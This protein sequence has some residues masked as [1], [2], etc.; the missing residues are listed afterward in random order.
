MSRTLKI[1]A[2]LVVVQALAVG[3]WFAVQRARSAKVT[4]TI[5]VLSRT[6]RMDR[7]APGLALKRLGGS[8]A[9]LSDFAGRPVVLHFWATWCGPC[10]DELPGLLALDKD[11]AAQ[12]LAVGLDS[13]WDSVRRFLGRD[14]PSSVFL[15]DSKMVEGAFNVRRL[16]VTYILD[17]RGRLRLRMDGP[18]SWSREGLRSAL[19][20]ARPKRGA[21]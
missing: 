15:A 14:L 10:R 16:P 13:R 1:V 2:A 3:A 4:P 18:R 19:R 20:H 5:S 8:V 17:A 7:P 12:V 11:G 6:T 9:R 21:F